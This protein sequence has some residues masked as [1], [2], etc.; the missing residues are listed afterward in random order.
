MI[1]KYLYCSGGL[2]V[3]GCYWWVSFVGMRK[4]SLGSTD[5]TVFKDKKNKQ[6]VVLAFLRTG[7]ITNYNIR[8][9][10]TRKENEHLVCGIIIVCHQDGEICTSGTPLTG[11]VSKL[12]FELFQCLVQLILC[13][14]ISS[15]MAEL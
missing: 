7:L 15:I 14:Q 1:K 11:L 9:T 8:N 5:F 2:L 10:P 13:H 12:T 4:T 6:G 3:V